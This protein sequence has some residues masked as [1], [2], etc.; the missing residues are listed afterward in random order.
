MKTYIK[1][2]TAITNIKLQSHLLIISNGDN[3]LQGSSNG[4]YADGVTLGSRRSSLW[5]DEDSEY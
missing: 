2:N 1:P 4:D 3:A 5:D